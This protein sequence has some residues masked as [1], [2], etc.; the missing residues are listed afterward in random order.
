MTYAL[1]DV[2]RTTYGVEP[3]CRVLEITPSGYYRHRVRATGPARRLARVQRDDTLHAEIRRV[4]RDHHEVDGVRNVW[5]RM[6]PSSS[7]GRASA[8]PAARSRG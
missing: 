3:I 1:I 8:S 4:W 7:A 6:L 5:Q 2:H